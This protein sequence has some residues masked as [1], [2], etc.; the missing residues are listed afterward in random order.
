MKGLFTRGGSTHSQTLVVAEIGIN[1]EGDVNKCRRM[2]HEAAR[3]G[4]DA[5]KL[6]TID[7]ATNYVP[8]SASFPLFDGAQLSRTETSEMFALA[9]SLGLHAFTTA[10]DVSTLNWVD[11]LDPLAHKISS[12]LLQH[13]PL[14]RHAAS[15]GRPL[16]IST[17]MSFLDEVRAAVEAAQEAGAREI[18]LLHCV[19]VYPVPENELQLAT[20]RFLADN[21]DLEVGFSDHSS[22]IYAAPLA[23]AA[24]ARIIEKHFTFDESRPSFD[25]AI[26]LNPAKFSAMVA[27][28]RHVESMLGDIR[29]GLSDAEANNRQ[30]FTRYLVATQFI[31]K[32][33]AF[34]S[35]N[36]AAMRTSG[37]EVGMRPKML[38][39]LLGS[40]A[41]VDIERYATITPDVVNP[42]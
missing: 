21:F 12:G 37:S 2:I 36:V 17:G 35:L 28:I 15:T 39:L 7:P 13:L 38:D 32:G 26:S 25:H 4:A 29:T 34:T 11:A 42:R 8:T 33:S 31:P 3:S 6:Q 20:I 1:H 27:S 9:R 30:K 22:G 5:I 19:S 41:K 10:G 24:G 23:V 40:C 18:A 16:I 14:I